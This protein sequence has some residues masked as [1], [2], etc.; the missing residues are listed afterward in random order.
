MVEWLCNNMKNIKFANLAIF[1]IFFG[2]ALFNA[3][4]KHNWVEVVLFLAL[5]IIF[6]WADTKKK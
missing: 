6:F 1:I 4:Q 3:F 2:T 5:G